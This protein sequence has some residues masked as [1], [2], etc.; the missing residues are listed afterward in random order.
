[1][2]EENVTF[3]PER[4]ASQVTTPG[5]TFAW[6]AT[7]FLKLWR[8]VFTFRFCYFKENDASANELAKEVAAER[9][10]SRTEVQTS[11][12]RKRLEKKKRK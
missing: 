10:Q 1:M 2:P 6:Y 3:F 7:C 9:T 8:S 5:D 12:H 4:A 11:S